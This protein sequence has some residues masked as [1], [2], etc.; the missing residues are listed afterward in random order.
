ERVD[1]PQADLA[2]PR[3]AGVQRRVDRR[4]VGVEVALPAPAA[5]VRVDAAVQRERRAVDRADDEARLLGITVRVA[6]QAREAREDGARAGEAA[7][8]AR[9][10]RSADV[11]APVLGEEAPVA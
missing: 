8:R 7:E 5:L 11:P 3:A 6:D 2:A 1:R 9:Q 4:V 10:V